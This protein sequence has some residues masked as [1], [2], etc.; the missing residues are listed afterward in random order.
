M[1]EPDGKV[2]E[3]YCIKDK[4]KREFV[5]EAYARWSNGTPVAKGTCPDCG[6]PLS[7]VL[8]KAAAAEIGIDE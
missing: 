5:V 4:G 8:S 1:T 2:Y 3:A 7:R 6:N